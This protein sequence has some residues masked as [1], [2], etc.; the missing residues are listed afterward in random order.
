RVACTVEQID[1]RSEEPI[2][3]SRH[4]IVVIALC[5]AEIS[6]GD[7]HVVAVLD[8]SRKLRQRFGRAV[9]VRAE[10]HHDVAANQRPRL[11]IRM[12]N[13]L[14]PLYVGFDALLLGELHAAVLGATVDHQNLIKGASRNLRKDSLEALDLVQYW[15]EQGGGGV[16]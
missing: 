1:Q 11:D 7:D 10:R 5:R 2:S 8:G 14:T 16:A 9:A 6:R 4:H 13:P 15:H 3:K 12:A